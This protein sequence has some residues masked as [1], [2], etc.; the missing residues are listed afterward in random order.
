MPFVKTELM[1][2]MVSMDELMVSMEEL[3]QTNEFH[4]KPAAFPEVNYKKRNWSC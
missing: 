1:N 3:M 2:A 4:F